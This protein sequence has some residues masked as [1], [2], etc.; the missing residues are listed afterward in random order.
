MPSDRTHNGARLADTR[1]RI[2]NGKV[3]FLNADGL[4]R[5]GRLWRDT[6]QPLMDTLGGDDAVTTYRRDL[7]ADYADLTLTIYAAQKAALGWR[8]R[9]H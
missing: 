5:E 3:L 2:T 4:S 1:S 9:A 8:L 7:V 6:C